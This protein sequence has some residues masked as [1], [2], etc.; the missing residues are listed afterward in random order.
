MHVRIAGIFN[1]YGP[2]M[3]IVDGRVVSNFVA[4]ALRKE[5]MT[6]Y[7]DEKQTRSFPC[8]SD[9]VSPGGR[10]NAVDGS[11]VKLK[12]ASQCGQ[13]KTLSIG[14]RRTL[15]K[16]VLTAL[17]LYYMSIYKA[18]AAV[19]KDLESTRRDFSM[20]LISLIKVIHGVKGNI[21]DSQTKISGSIWQE[22]VHEFASVKSKGINFVSFIKRKLENE[23]NTLFW[24]D[25]W[26]AEKI[27]NASLNLSFRCFPGSRI[28]DEQ[29]NNLASITSN[30]LLPQIHDRWSWS[31]NASGDFM[32]NILAW[33]ISM[34]RL[35]T[36]F[37]LP[38][39]SLEI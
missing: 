35:P 19:L 14:G 3:C 1:T 26:L 30:V 38:S 13:I 9:L 23:E 17:P 10:S 28:E 7:G 5:P 36:R 32:T 29:Y 2:R 16:S 34:D 27:G 4:Q 15:F 22:L 31:L 11:A 37:N 25:I 20:V 6:V 21:N 8:V 33:K 12:Q 39:H 18:H 24:E